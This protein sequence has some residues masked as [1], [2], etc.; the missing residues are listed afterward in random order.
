MCVAEHFFFFSF[1][2]SQQYTKGRG[3][4]RV[5]ENK[6]FCFKSSA[7]SLS[8][9]PSSPSSSVIHSVSR[10]CEPRSTC[11]RHLPVPR[12]E[13]SN[14]E[15]PAC[16]V[17]TLRSLFQHLNS[18]HL[19]NGETLQALFLSECRIVLASPARPTV[20]DRCHGSGMSHL[21]PPESPSLRNIPQA[22]PTAVTGP[23]LRS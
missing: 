15:P 3:T 4:L 1:Y 22:H 14:P 13:L 6:I 12:G 9:T 18:C 17:S 2:L 20:L 19:V 8:S 23:S 5:C 10:G 7:Q 11:L 16:Q 21:L